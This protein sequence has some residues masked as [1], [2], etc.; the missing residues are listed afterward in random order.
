M[1]AAIESWQ[2]T[3]PISIFHSIDLRER[4]ELPRPHRFR[5][6][7]VGLKET[8]MRV[9]EA[10]TR[11]VRVA[12]PNQSICDAACLM[13]QID[14]GAIPVG[15][16]DR[17]V[18]IITDRDIAIRAVAAGKGPDTQVRE[19]MTP[20]VKYCFEDE[21]VDHVARNMGELRVRRLPVVNRDKRLVGILSLGDIALTEGKEPAGEAITKVSRPGG[22]HS[23]STAP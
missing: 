2:G 7:A 5:V 6:T 1:N 23:Q 22:R 18:G 19:I 20:D 9:A 10:M 8:I 14:A 16:D 3:Q 13:A 4:N 17:L 15:Q 12:N 21:D 11:E